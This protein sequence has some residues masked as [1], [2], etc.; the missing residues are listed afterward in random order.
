MSDQTPQG[1][2]DQVPAQGYS[3]PGGVGAQP[4]QQVQQP[5]Q[6]PAP[7]ISD[8]AFNQF[9]NT[10]VRAYTDQQVARA[11]QALEAKL[12]E[13][14]KKLGIEQAKQPEEQP[15]R[16]PTPQAPPV[17]QPPVQPPPAQVMPPGVPPAPADFD[18]DPYFAQIDEVVYAL[19]IPYDAPELMSIMQKSR[20]GVYGDELV[21]FAKS[22]GREYAVRTQGEPPPEPASPNARL[23]G[24]APVE[25]GPVEQNEIA[26]IVDP[27]LLWE[28]HLEKEARNRG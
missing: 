23:G 2:A 25:G 5:D 4:Q 22:K 11:T 28:K 20:E 14:E 18:F 7:A 3:P 16:Q 12:A 27:D 10:R 17:P 24:I 19:D 9:F 1:S 8:E 15:Q 13:Y 26:D 6:A 21:A